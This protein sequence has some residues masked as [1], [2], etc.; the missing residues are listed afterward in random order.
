MLE[1]SCT[2]RP[3]GQLELRYH[4]SG[5]FGAAA[6]GGFGQ[7]APSPGDIFNAEML[8]AGGLG[9]RYQLTS[10]F[11]MHLR[12]DYSWGRDGGLLYFGVGEAF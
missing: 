10:K 8:L 12:L 7:V 2:H 5:R 1:R 11:P 3:T 9:A 4:S 6:F